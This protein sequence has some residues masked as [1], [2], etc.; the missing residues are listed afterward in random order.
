LSTGGGRLEELRKDRDALQKLIVDIGNIIKEA[1]DPAQVEARTSFEQARLLEEREAEYGKAIELYEKVLANKDDAKL[2]ERLGRLKEAWKPKSD[3]HKEAR[4]F[5]YDVW[6]QD[7]DA[8]TMKGR[9]D[10]A[11]AAFQACKDTKDPLGPRRLV[12]VAT[13]H[14]GKLTKQ[15]EAL[16]P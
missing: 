9:L 13:A 4:A 7:A 16:A 12:K 14:A 8:R 1:N 11:R 15:Y 6:P 10:E 2:R 3:K 5:I